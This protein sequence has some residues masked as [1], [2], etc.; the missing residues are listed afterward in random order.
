MRCSVG[1]KFLIWAAE[2]CQTSEYKPR[3][4]FVPLVKHTE[5]RKCPVFSS[6]EA[7]VLVLEGIEKAGAYTVYTSEWNTM[8]PLHESCAV[9]GW[10]ASNPLYQI[11]AEV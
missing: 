2:P 5:V 9:N 4:Y 1:A 7:L 3:D 6:R 8:I 10:R 11:Q